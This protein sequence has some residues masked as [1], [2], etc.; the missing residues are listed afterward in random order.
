MHVIPSEGTCIVTGLAS[1]LARPGLS[2]D[3]ASGLEE[4]GTSR[5]TSCFSSSPPHLQVSRPWSGGEAGLVFGAQG[6][7]MRA[8][9]WCACPMPTQRQSRPKFGTSS[10]PSADTPPPPPPQRG[11][12]FNSPRRVPRGPPAPPPPPPPPLPT[13]FFPAYA[14]PHTHLALR[15]SPTPTLRPLPNALPIPNL[16]RP[17]PCPV[18]LVPEALRRRIENRKLDLAVNTTR[19]V[20][21]SPPR[22][23]PGG[24]CFLSFCCC[25][26]CCCCC[27][28]YYCCCSCSCRRRRCACCVIYTPPCLLL[29]YRL[30]EAVPYARLLRSP[31]F[32]PTPNRSLRGYWVSES[33][34]RARRN[35]QLLNW[36]K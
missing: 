3:R 11:G 7:R 23:V 12:G 6:P 13:F 22:F 4:A 26:C 25:C 16:E 32:R 2:G 14:R 10:Y 30:N 31:R 24:P 1:I 33:D 17:Q 28:C 21:D 34:E 15:R 29:I 35:T 18:A 20:F 36:P 5:A 8:R 27:F 9:G 19:C